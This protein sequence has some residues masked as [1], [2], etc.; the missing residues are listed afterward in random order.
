M[1]KLLAA[2]LALMML[3]TACAACAESDTNTVVL[4]SPEITF[5]VKGETRS[6]SLSGFR[7]TLAL[8]LSGMTPTAQ[9]QVSDGDTALLGGV[10]QMNGSR[11]LASVD[12]MGRA[13]SLDLDR[14]S[15][16]KEV[17]RLITLAISSA[18]SLGGFSLE[19]AISMFTRPGDDGA[20]TAEFRVPSRSLARL[21]KKALTSA[22]NISV[23]GVGAEDI[24][25]LLGD[26]DGS[27]KG[28]FTYDPVN[29]AFSVSL[30]QGRVSMAVTG[31]ISITADRMLLRSAESFGGEVD[32]LSLDS[33]GRRQ[34]A[35]ELAEALSPLANYLIRAGLS[36]FLPGE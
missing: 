32:V 25:A 7:A 36:G 24:E 34:A 31:Y 29:N 17:S 20:R 18:A 26:I 1:K 6:V 2:A 19:G 11:V 4:G 5:T 10:A 9:L 23:G 12:G 28:V 33:E 8:G 21:A 35:Q 15:G 27:A 22:G 13:Y 14:L 3:L 16:D 30:A